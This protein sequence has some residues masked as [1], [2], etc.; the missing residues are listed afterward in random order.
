MLFVIIGRDTRDA[1]QK[2]PDIRPTHLAYFES[3]YKAGRVVLA[4]PLTDGAGSLIVLQ[5]DS[6]AEAWRLMMQDPYIA[7]GVFESVEIHPFNRVFPPQE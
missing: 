7:S 4:G 1:R 5:A 3:L 6:L 2:R